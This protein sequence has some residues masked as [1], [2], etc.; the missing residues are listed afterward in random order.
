VK[1]RWSARAVRHLEDISDYIALDD[2]QAAAR[3]IARIRE[4]A[5][6]AAA[7]PLSGRRVPELDDEAIREVLLRNYRIVYGI[8]E[9]VVVVIA[10]CE[11]HLPLERALDDE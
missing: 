7:M 1:S 9:S 4:R 5:R 10:V 3:W 8:L 6:K 2:P 11:G